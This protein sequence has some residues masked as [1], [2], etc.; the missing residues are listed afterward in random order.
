MKTLLAA[1]KDPFFRLKIQ[2][3]EA[4]DLTNTDEAKMALG[5]VEKLAQNDSKTLVQAAAIS[6]LVKTKNAKYLPWYEKNMSALSNSVKAS[7][8]AGIAAVDSAK[9][10][11]LAEKM[12]LSTASDDLMTTLLPTIVDKKITSQ[13][14]AIGKLVAFYPFL[15][16]RNP[17]LGTKAEA[18]FNWI[19]SSDNTEAT[20]NI[21]KILI[22]A[23]GQVEANPQAKMM[24][25]KMLQDG[26]VKKTEA[27]KA[28]PSSASLKTQVEELNKTIEAYK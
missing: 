5:D 16:M 1:L 26:L 15:K 11:T 3:L 8:L 25:V 12:D 4:L 24:I 18:G 10:A 28:N 9:A 7:S 19:M 27:L 2:A 17:D 23:K 22:Q 14:P 13:M 21:T 20:H 6:A